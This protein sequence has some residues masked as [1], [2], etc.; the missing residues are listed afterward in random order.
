MTL[1]FLS[2]L[3]I[4]CSNSLLWGNW[5]TLYIQWDVQP[6][7]TYGVKRTVGCYDLS[8]SD[9]LKLYI[10]LQMN[11]R[12]RALANP[13]VTGNRI[14]KNG[15]VFCYATELSTMYEVKQRVLTWQHEKP[16]M[17]SGNSLRDSTENVTKQELRGC[18]LMVEEQF[19]QAL[20]TCWYSEWCLTSPWL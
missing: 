16:F 17:S 8:D 4:I 5:A 14:L 6:V 15:V 9:G 7:V 10:T 2:G 19:L 1:N 12:N 18:Y 13:W 3:W 11:Y 20:N